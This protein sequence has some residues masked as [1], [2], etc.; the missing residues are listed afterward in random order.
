MEQVRNR[1]NIRLVADEN[2][3]L[4]AVVKAS[5]RKCEIIN[6]DLVMVRGAR[7]KIKLNKPIAVRFTILD[8]SKLTMYEFY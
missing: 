2:K 1:V 7:Q 4:K 8:I 5:F 6:E 3:F